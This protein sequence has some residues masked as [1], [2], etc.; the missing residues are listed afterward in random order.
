MTYNASELILNQDGSIYHLNLRPEDIADTIILV[1][2]PARVPRVSKHF[3]RIEVQKSK[4]E[5][6]THTGFIGKKRLS[7]VGTGIGVG[8]I[9]IVM[10]ELDALVNIDLNTR[11]LKS[12]M[13][14]LQLC[15]LGTAG[16]LQANLP[17]DGLL[18]SQYAL[19]LDG[20]LMHY[21]RKPSEELAVLLNKAKTALANLP[22]A[23]STYVAKGDAA[24]VAD[25]LNLPGATAGITATC[26]GF[27]APQGRCLR[28]DSDSGQLF[29]ALNQIHYAG[30]SVTNLE[31]ETAAIY[32]LSELL[33]HKACSISTLVANRATGE[34]SKSPEIAID[35]MIEAALSRLA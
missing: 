7:V 14:Q 5:F 11:E 18:V 17:V 33:G 26:I 34:F 4:R 35:R 23:S 12:T 16:A 21:H 3:D 22:S 1:G 24:M 28:L 20:L 19:G 10:N 6:V 2:D 30:L 25:F 8:N 29:T 31:M 15:R 27:Y 13:T 32:G 9:G